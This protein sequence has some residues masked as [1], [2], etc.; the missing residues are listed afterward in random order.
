M[1]NLTYIKVHWK[2]NFSDEPILLFSELDD[3]RNEIRKVEIYRDDLMGYACEDISRNGTFL[4]E[5]ELPELSVINENTQF[6]GIEI[7]KE[8]FE[9]MWK[10][11]IDTQ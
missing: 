4:S 8:Q 2:H 3:S 7:D 1:I 10:K 5:C 6:E 9:K 11:A